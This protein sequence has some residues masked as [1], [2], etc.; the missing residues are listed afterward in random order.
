MPS[1]WPV[2]AFEAQSERD[3]V[4]ERIDGRLPDALRG[5][6]YRIGP[7]TLDAAGEPNGHWFDGDGMICA[8]A[9]GDGRALFRNRYVA[10]PWYQGRTAR[11]AAPLLEF[12]R[13]LHRPSA[14]ICSGPR[15]PP[16]PTWCRMPAGLLALYEAGRPFAVDAATLATLG[17]E[18]F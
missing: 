4:I 9:L 11:R 1:S 15:I 5:T 17:E 12:S 18:S 3:V 8:F 13:R 10:T 7:S 14:A 2:R 16:T 6:F